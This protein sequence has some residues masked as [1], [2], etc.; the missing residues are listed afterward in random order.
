MNSIP[1]VLVTFCLQKQHVD[2]KIAQTLASCCGRDIQRR[3][4]ALAS[5]L[6]FLDLLEEYEL[7]PGRTSSQGDSKIARRNRLSALYFFVAA[8]VKEGQR[9]ADVQ[10]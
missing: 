2:L 9:Q 6:V 7:L 10:R 3:G 4:Y 8:R 1:S 5:T